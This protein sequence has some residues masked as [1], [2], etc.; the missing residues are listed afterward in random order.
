M[1]QRR[2]VGARNTANSDLH[3]Y[4]Q[5]IN[6]SVVRANTTITAVQR[7]CILQTS[8]EDM[9]KYLQYDLSPRLRLFLFFEEKIRN[10]T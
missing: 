9:K 4:F 5:L 3:N 10:G 1:T 6:S 8:E 7:I 2:Q